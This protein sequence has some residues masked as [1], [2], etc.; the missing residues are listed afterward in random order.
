MALRPPALAWLAG[1]LGCSCQAPETPGTP[2]ALSGRGSLPALLAF[3]THCLAGRLEPATSPE[4]MRHRA[5]T[6]TH[7]DLSLRWLRDRDGHADTLRRVCLVSSVPLNVA[8]E[9]AR[10]TSFG[11]I[12]RSV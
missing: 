11:S 7:A 3:E 5:R 9:T 10:D 8:G 2:R 6:S 4:V 12:D 1:L